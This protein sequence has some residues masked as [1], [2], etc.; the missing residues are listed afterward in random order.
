MLKHIAIT[1]LGVMAL[2]WKPV[3]GQV[4]PY[5]TVPTTA[6]SFPKDTIPTAAGT[7]DFWARLSGFSGPLPGDQGTLFLF[8]IHDGSTKSSYEMGFVP[9]DGLG[10]KGLTSKVGSIFGTGSSD[11]FTG[12]DNT[13]EDVLGAGGLNAWHHYTLKWNEN[14]LAG[15]PGYPD[16]ESQRLALY[17]DGALSSTSWHRTFSGTFPALEG[18]V[19]NMMA[20]GSPTSTFPSGAKVAIDEFRIFDGNGN[21]VFYNTFDSIQDVT[22][23]AVGLNGSFNGYGNPAFVPGILGNALEAA[24]LPGVALIPE[25]EIYAMLLAGLCLLRTMV[26]RKTI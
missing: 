8:L 1:A 5:V 15:L 25:P 19:L 20:G 2:A 9:N 23:S 26:R 17:L 6:V 18:G 4:D 7:I 21:L 11:F 13:F 3:Y 10:S 24:P 22:H 12:P 16:P 14:R